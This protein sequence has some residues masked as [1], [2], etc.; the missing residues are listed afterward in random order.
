MIKKSG[1]DCSVPT[2]IRRNGEVAFFSH[3]ARSAYD[4]E[5][6][7]DAAGQR[8]KRK[9]LAQRRMDWTA[10]HEI[11]ETRRVKAIRC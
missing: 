1:A 6:Q 7:G 11:K 4:L 2:S 9:V 10:P 5:G 3:T 8:E